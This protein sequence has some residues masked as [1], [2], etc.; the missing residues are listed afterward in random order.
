MIGTTSSDSPTDAHAAAVARAFGLSVRT[1]RSEARPRGATSADLA[2][3]TFTTPPTLLPRTPARLPALP[4]HLRH[5][6]R[7]RRA[8]KRQT[9]A[10]GTASPGY[11]STR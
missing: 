4:H 9:G 10:D 2:P 3:M 11:G 6:R 5:L 1:I 7:L 8:R